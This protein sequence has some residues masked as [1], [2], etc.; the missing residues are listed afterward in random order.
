MVTHFIA[1]SANIANQQ[2][3]TC[4]G[5]AYRIYLDFENIAQGAIPS[6]FTKERNVQALRV[7]TVRPSC[8]PK[9][10]LFWA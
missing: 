6:G 3:S 1:G 5:G 7:C 8:V 9:N 4:G 10:T 2:S